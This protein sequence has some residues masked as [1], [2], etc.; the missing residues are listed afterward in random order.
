VNEPAERLPQNWSRGKL[1]DLIYI[2]GRIGWRG[3]KADEYTPSGPLFFSVHNLNKGDRVSFAG[4][5]HISQERY[6]ES[7]E[8]QLQNNDILLAKD[9]A[10]I[11]K[12]GIVKELKEKATVNS[13]LLVIRSTGV[14]VPEFL[15]YFLKGPAMQ[16]IVKERITGSATPHLFQRDIKKF[17]LLIPPITE[18]QRIA[19]KI[20]ELFTKLDA[21]V[22]S[23]KAANKQLKR[24]RHSVLK[25]AVEGELTREWREKH[26][27]ALEPASVLLERILCERRARWEAD[28]LT[29]MQAQGKLPEDDKWKAKYQE[30]GPLSSKDLPK[31]P[32]EWVWARAEQLCDF[33]T[34]GTTP[35]KKKLFQ[36]SGEVPYIKVYNLTNY[37]ALDFTI[38]PTFVSRA[39]HTGELSR[40]KV[41]PGDVLMNIVG[42]PL[43]K[44][45]IVPNIYAEWNINQAIAI[46]RPMP[47]R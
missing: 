44:V 30:P 12:L 28:Q 13:S 21:G 47:T 15:F 37:G 17:E 42:P 24:Y 14:F 6:E 39:T 18:Q 27:N 40:S 22:A 2:A 41:F 31:L 34:K 26:R 23:L 7:P 35:D 32:A 43:G 19:T 1:D 33:I 8:I 11:G 36:Q 45:S 16:R 38:N 29:K 10:G 9:G 3:L 20:E 25:A 46:F 5:F 4:A